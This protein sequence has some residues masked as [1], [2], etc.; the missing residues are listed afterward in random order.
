MSYGLLKSLAYSGSI[1]FKKV[2]TGSIEL[3][4]WKY[5]TSGN[6]TTLTV[7]LDAYCEENK[8][9][10]E[11]V[12]EFYDNLGIC[13]AYH[14][15]N[16]NSYSGTFTDVIFTDNA[17]SNMNLTAKDSNDNPIYHKGLPFSYDT[18]TPNTKLTNVFNPDEPENVYGTDDNGVLCKLDETGKP[19]TDVINVNDLYF[20]DGGTLYSNLLYFARIVIKYCYKDADGNYDENNKSDFRYFHRYFWTNSMFN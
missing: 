11:V 15:A 10:K 17:S 20:N 12:I 4:K 7:G 2:G 9:I 16:R 3:N 19:T 6:S 13:A 1:D 8:G 5:Y 14:I 18:L